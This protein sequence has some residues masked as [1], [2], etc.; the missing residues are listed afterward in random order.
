MNF[1]IPLLPRH[2]DIPRSQPSM[3]DVAIY[4]YAANICRPYPAAQGQVRSTATLGNEWY[5]YISR[6]AGWV[7][8]EAENAT[9][10]KR[11]HQNRGEE[12]CSKCYFSQKSNNQK[13]IVYL[14]TKINEY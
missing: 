12:N 14:Q 11:P 9:A 6:G 7:C 2:V 10:A 4:L 5:V 3:A 1:F 8:D 13:K